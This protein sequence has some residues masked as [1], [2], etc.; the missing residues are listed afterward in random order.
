MKL[1]IDDNEIRFRG[2]SDEFQDVAKLL[3][4][5]ENDGDLHVCE[6][7]KNNWVIF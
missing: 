3:V 7:L 6:A 2:R 4:A 1:V 5:L